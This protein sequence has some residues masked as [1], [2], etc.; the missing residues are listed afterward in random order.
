[1]ILNIFSVVKK[2]RDRWF[3]VNHIDYSATLHGPFSR[4][5]VKAGSLYVAF[6]TTIERQLLCGID[7]KCA[8]GSHANSA[9]MRVLPLTTDGHPP[10]S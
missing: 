7:G 10:V 3:L 9:L 8:P 1:M 6:F 2:Y 5:I 4:K